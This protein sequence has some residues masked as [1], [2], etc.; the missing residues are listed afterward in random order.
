MRKNW[1]DIKGIKRG[2]LHGWLVEK[3]LWRKVLQHCGYGR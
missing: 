2:V 1:E 3:L